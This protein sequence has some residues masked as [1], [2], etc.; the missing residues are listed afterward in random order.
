MKL[1]KLLPIIALFMVVSLFGCKKDEDN[2][3]RPTVSS[4]DPIIEATSIAI[5][6][7]ISATFN[8]ALDPSTVTVESFTLFQ[9][10]TK[11]PG[12][13]ECV[14]LTVV[15]TPSVNLDQNTIY[16][17]TITSL[18][19][20]KSGKAMAENYS[21][22]F[23][24]GLIQDKTAPTV[25]LTNP[26]SDAT[27]AALKGVIVITFSEAMNLATID[28]LTIVVKQLFTTV[29]GTV[30]YADSK[31]TFTPKTDL[32]PSKP[33]TVTVKTRAKDMAGNALISKYTFGFTS[34]AIPVI[35]DL[36]M[37][38]V[39]LTTP[40]NDATG[41][42]LDPKVVITFSEPM[43]QNTIT[44]ST[45]TIQEGL[46]VVSGSITKTDTTASYTPFVKFKNEKNYTVT[47][48][49]GV[50]DKRGNALADKYVFSFTT[51][52][53]QDL[54]LPTVTLTSPAKNSTGASVKPQVVITFSEPMD[55]TTLNA[56]NLI[57]KQ[58][59]NVVEGLVSN[60]SKTVTFIPSV[61]LTYSTTYTVT[62]LTGVKDLEGNALV[63]DYSFKFTT[64][65]EPDITAPTVK[66]TNPLNNAI[67]VGIKTKIDITFNEPMNRRS[68]SVST[69]KLMQGTANVVGIV[70]GWGEKIAFIPQY[71][72]E[73]ST[74]YT[75]TISTA[76]KDTA[77]NALAKDYT[78]SFTTVK[79][80]VV[81]PLKIDL[82][83][84]LKNAIDVALDGKINI[85][86]SVPMDQSTITSST[87]KLMQGVNIVPGV[88]TGSG[89]N[90]TFT[91]DANLEL[92]K[93]YTVIVTTGV[94]DT[95]GNALSHEYTFTFGSVSLPVVKTI[96]PVNNAIDVALDGKINISFSN[97]MD[98]STITSSTFKLMEGVNI[99]P[100]VVTGSD[101]KA[102]FTPNDNLV[103]NKTYT[104]TVTTG[105]MD[106]Y[107]NALS[108]DYT[109][110]FSSVSLPVVNATDPLNN[111]ID[112][113][114]NKVVAITFSEKMK[115]STINS[116]TFTLKQGLA[117]IVGNV[118]YSGYKATFT[119]SVILESNK[120][121]TA[122]ITTGA[123]DLAGNALATST[124]W[125]FTTINVA[126][127]LA[128]VYL[129]T[130]GNY[131]ILAKTTI[132]NAPTSD[133]TGDLGLSPAA[134]S[135]ITGFDLVKVG[136]TSATASQVTGNLYGADMTTPTNSNLTTAVL[137]MQA[138][139]TEAAGRPLPDYVNEYTGNLGGQTLLPG[140]YKWTTGVTIPSNVI[141]SGGADDVWI[142][143]IAGT[144]IMGNSVNVTLLGGAKA[145]NIFWQ[146]AGATTFGTNSHFEGIILCK[147]GITLKT[148]ASMN[149]RA[150]AQTAVIL[151]KNVFVEP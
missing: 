142:F 116:S 57:L 107:G 65:K 129:G 115:S 68:L 60:T 84:P 98:Q 32:L 119:P 137:D 16:K 52:K 78:F 85:R 133:I 92:D 122:T 15:F 13:I 43:N 140:L 127:G 113:L 74:V 81:I 1:K 79:P 41:V 50:K 72:L 75:V 120:I 125:N 14:G 69:I 106:K 45:F 83:D 144:L 26:L 77:G 102:T 59:E 28:S 90:A 148:G 141:I 4:T 49:T 109:Y 128:P 25:V 147:T 30:T 88:V 145:S 118:A 5:N 131:V 93:I 3:L 7:K 11:I 67:N 46:N 101:S 124:T 66:N 38:T 87:F 36:V 96:D 117:T 103:L 2:S 139:Y 111:A 112:V 31:A 27:E 97:L 114:H 48:S 47:I 135:F 150:L 108:S 126:P 100:G 130:A 8:V 23:T 64:T 55:Q 134:T 132:T 18:V 17:A 149:G 136:T 44:G 51:L 95:D 76:A 35:P 9:G 29:S 123:K 63:K 19:K 39:V 104:V 70:E 6:T 89:S 151:D 94:K 20:N 143:Q 34:A 73:N 91:P 33:Y 80:K 58:G 105:V 62:I 12:T 82:T 10:T 99:V 71:N 22:S 21:W 40:V 24:S 56:S 42:A 54:T 110:S 138:A 146:V 61:D 53:I 86:F 121:Y 37:P